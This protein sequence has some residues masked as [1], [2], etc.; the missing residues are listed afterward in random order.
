MLN[1]FP[2]TGRNLKSRSRLVRFVRRCRVIDGAVAMFGLVLA[3]SACHLASAQRVFRAGED[4]WHPIGL[5]CCKV[6]EDGVSEVRLF[7]IADGEAERLFSK[8][9]P[10]PIKTP[11]CLSNAVVVV[12]TD[13]AITKLNISGEAVFSQKLDDFA[14][15]ALSVGRL[16]NAEVFITEAAEGANKRQLT[17]YLYVIDVSG[18]RPVVK[19]KFG[20]IQPQRVAVAGDEIVVI[21]LKKTQRLKMPDEVPSKGK[22]G[23]PADEAGQGVSH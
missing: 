1:T 22:S 3:N 8:H 7:R 19:R 4:C 16:S 12:N 6:I 5:F 20:I 15:V 23:L 13:G 18:N 2:S 10:A 14:G 17:F 9:L 11:I 21:G